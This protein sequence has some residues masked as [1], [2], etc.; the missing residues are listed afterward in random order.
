LVSVGVGGRISSSS[1]QANSFSYWLMNKQ[2][3]L[4]ADYKFTK[5]VMVFKKKKKKSLF[6]SLSFLLVIFVANVFNSKFFMD[7]PVIDFAQHP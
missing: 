7:F 1:E 3:K 2:S 4:Q 5:N 6:I